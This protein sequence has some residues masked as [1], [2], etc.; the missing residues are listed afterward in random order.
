[1]NQTITVPKVSIKLLREQR[2]W[3]LTLDCAIN[4]SNAHGLIN[5]LDNMLD[6]A[7]GFNND[8]TK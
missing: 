5:L 6:I 8:K 3:L 4:D 1:M 2:N 7:E